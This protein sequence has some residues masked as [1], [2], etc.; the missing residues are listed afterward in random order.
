MSSFIG[1][2]VCISAHLQKT[3]L[4][5]RGVYSVHKTITHYIVNRAQKMQPVVADV[6]YIQIGDALG[7][8]CEA[9][10]KFEVFPALR[11]NK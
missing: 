7:G 4:K 2:F 1:I 3:Q 9:P 6:R 11:T 8:L 10:G 5:L